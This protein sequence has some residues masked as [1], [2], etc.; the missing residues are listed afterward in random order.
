[1]AIYRYDKTLKVGRKQTPHSLLITIILVLIIGLIGYYLL[2]RNN[3]QGAQSGK[4][5]TVSNDPYIEFE[6]E[7]YKFKVS[8]AWAEAIDIGDN[9]GTFVYRKYKGPNPLGILTIK[10]NAGAP[11]LTTNVV[12][13]EVIEGKIVKIGSVSEHCS[14][15]VPQGSNLDPHIVTGEG[16]SFRCWTDGTTFIASAGSKG[17]NLEIPLI[18]PNGET[19]KYSVSYQSTSFETDHKAILEVLKTFETR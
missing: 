9:Q 19:A 15:Y 6:T 2:N 17:G 14:K 13:I 4:A 7:Y 1:M 12:P 11:S 8:K 5:V 16:V 3:D 18:R 10:V